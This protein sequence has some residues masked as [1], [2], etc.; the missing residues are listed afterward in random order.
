MPPRKAACRDFL[1]GFKFLYKSFDVKG[2]RKR[3]ATG[4]GMRKQ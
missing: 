1:L 4:N 3:E 2:V